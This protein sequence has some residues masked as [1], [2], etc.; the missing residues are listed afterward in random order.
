MQAI[1]ADAI[2]TEAENLIAFMLQ[3]DE[4]IRERLRRITAMTEL[5]CKQ[6]RKAGSA[7]DR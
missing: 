7:N 4:E 5:Q 6:Q 3:R 2:Q 1:R